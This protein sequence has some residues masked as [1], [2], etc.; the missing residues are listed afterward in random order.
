M[1]QII[2]SSIERKAPDDLVFTRPDGSAPGDF[3]Q[4]WAA[5]CD[6]AGCSGL[7]FHE[8]R[9]TGA[10]NMRRLGIPENVIMKIGGWKTA[11][12]FRHYD[13][14]DQTGLADANRRTE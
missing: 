2:G 1:F 6:R 4:A 9:R 7:L 14:V 8:L 12:L 13:I 5:A 11:S 3:R 10:R